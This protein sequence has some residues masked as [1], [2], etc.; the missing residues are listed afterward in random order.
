MLGVLILVMPSLV[1]VPLV[2]KV[3]AH[4]HLH[5]KTLVRRNA[6]QQRVLVLLMPMIVH[7]TEGRRMSPR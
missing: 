2:L 3:L 1:L 6:V 7:A 5:L 4:T